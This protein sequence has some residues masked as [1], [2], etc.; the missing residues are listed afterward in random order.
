MDA[1]HV[2]AARR[3]GAAEFVTGEHPEKPLFRVRD[4][5]VRS[6]QD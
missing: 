4:I 5:V 6:L 3:L 1:L 2:T